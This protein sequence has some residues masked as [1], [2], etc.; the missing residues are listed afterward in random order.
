M[1]SVSNSERVLQQALQAKVASQALA[2]LNSQQKA[3]ALEAMAASLEAA[4][5]DI[6]FHN[7]IDVEAARETGLSDALIERLILTD[8]SIQSMARGVREIAKQ[9]DPIGE[10][11]ETIER[12]NGIHIEKTRVPL[13]VVGIIYESR[14][15]V[16]VDAATLCLKAGNAVILRGGSEA[17]NS[18]RALVMALNKAAQAERLPEGAIQ[19]LDDT[20]REGIKELTHLHQLVDLVVARGS[21][22]MINSVMQ[23]ATVPVL[24]HGKGVCHVYVDDK[25]DLAMAQA[26]AFNAK[27]QRPGVCNAMETLL[28]HKD[29]AATFL[30]KIGEAYAGAKVEIRGDDQTRQFIKNAQPATED[31]WHTEYLDLIV[32]IRVVPSLE[33][34]IQHINQYGSHHSDSI[35]TTDAQHADRFLRSVDSAAVFHNASTRLHDGG[36]FGLGA[37]IGI[38]TRKLHARGTMGARELTTT[39]YVVRGTG[40]IRE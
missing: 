35:V 21:E 24:G 17:I 2:T 25:A 15:N 22:E 16:T 33:D 28:V 8:K 9:S 29:V 18:N 13:G 34:A 27:V 26:I 12:P 5:A 23:Q 30:P 10:I 14:P 3:R 1:T 39:K 4:S 37:E 7:E 20:S 36:V 32:S 6:L 11:L 40:Q 38:S 19:L 31:D